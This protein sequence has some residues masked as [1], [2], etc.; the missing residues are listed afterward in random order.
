MSREDRHEPVVYYAQV[1]GAAW[2][3]IGT[4]T[5]MGNRTIV[6][7]SPTAL[8]YAPGDVIAARAAGRR[9]E[10]LATE[11]GD[12]VVEVAR[13]QAFAAVRHSRSEWFKLDDRLQA[14]IAGLGPFDPAAIEARLLGPQGNVPIRTGRAPGRPPLGD[15]ARTVSISVKISRRERDAFVEQYGTAGAAVRHFI[16]QQYAATA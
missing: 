6:L 11:P 15:E 4:T 9:V 1:P 8:R 14:H 2:V 10:I 13:H 12:D 3:K 5:R 7:N 16:N